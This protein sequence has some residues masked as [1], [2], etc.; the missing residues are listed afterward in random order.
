MDFNRMKKCLFFILLILISIFVYYYFFNRQKQL[1]NPLV[2]QPERPLSAYTLT[3]LK[4]TTFAGSSINLG[5]KIN[6]TDDSIRQL[7]Y[8][9]VP[10]K[11]GEKPNLKVSG[12]ITLPKKAGSY[13]VIVMLRG[14]IPDES[15][16]PGSGTQHAAEIFAKNGFITLAPDFLGYGESASPSVDPL[17]ARFQ[18]YTTALTL[19]SSISNLNSGLEA[20]YAGRTTADLKKIGLWGHSNGGQIVLTALAVS[21]VDYPT[22]LW[23]PVSKSF[24]YSILYYTDEFDDQGKALRKVVADFEKDYEAADFSFTNYLNLIKAPIQIHQGTAD[25]EV[26]FWWSEEFVADLKKNNINI[27]YLTYPGADHNMLPDQWSNVVNNT[28]ISYKEHFK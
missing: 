27:K 5:K 9:S 11:P 3:N 17:E 2:K 10:Q 16:Q 13:P 1:I 6:E 19:L 4:K 25:Q 8:F 14:Y 21:G 23:A 12:V 7:F 28:V 22:V 20:S 24:P 26:P 15:Y 18:T